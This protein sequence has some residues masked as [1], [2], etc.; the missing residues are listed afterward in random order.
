M[1]P[2]AFEVRL[3]GPEAAALLREVMIR[4][5]TGTVATDSSAY[6]ETDEDIAEQLR[7]GLGALLFDGGTLIG[8]GR[9]SEVPGPAG[10]LRTWVEF[11]RIGV[12]RERRGEGLGGLIPDRLEAEA[13]TRGY[14][15]VQLGVRD[16]QPRLT[17]WWEARGFTIASDVQLH[18]VNPLTPPPVCLRKWF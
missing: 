17:R 18:T 11:K 8:G 2:P 10:D 7:H 15:G 5:W 6:R 12:L 9:Y 3:C 1:I 14:A 13:R 4:C 16:D